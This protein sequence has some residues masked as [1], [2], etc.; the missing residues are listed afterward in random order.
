MMK[1][2]TKFMQNE[3]Y[4]DTLISNFEVLLSLFAINLPQ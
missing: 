1:T 3:Y 2:Q 4:F